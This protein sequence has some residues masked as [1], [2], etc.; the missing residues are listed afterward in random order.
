MRTKQEIKKY[1]KDLEERKE[2][3]CIGAKQRWN[4]AITALRWILEGYDK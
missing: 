1:I 2:G 3:L 4:R